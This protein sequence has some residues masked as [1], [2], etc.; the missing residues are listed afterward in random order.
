MILPVKTSTNNYNI[1]L[2]RGALNNISEFCDTN[3]KALV[4]TDD[5]VPEIYSKNVAA[6]FSKCVIK[7]ISQGEKSKNFNTYKELLDVLSENEFS[8][9]DCVVA[10]GGGV[11]GDLS[12][13]TAAT[14]MRG[15][16]FYNIPTTLLSQVDSSIGGKTAIDFGGY[17]NTVGAFYQP[18]AVIIDP[19]V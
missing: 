14:Y 16:T 19:T 10:V 11:V 7:T 13:F 12:G 18:S 3:K 4:V 5:G 6:Q 1:V 2:Q 17:K 15:I 8:R 9:T